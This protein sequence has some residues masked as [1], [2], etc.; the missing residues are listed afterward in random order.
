M[1]NKVSGGGVM[2]K[3]KRVFLLSGT[4]SEGYGVCYNFDT[5]DVTP[6][7]VTQTSPAISKA[8]WNDARRI[9]VEYPSVG[10]N[11]HFAGVISHKSDGVVGP[12]WIEIHEPGSI[13][14]VYAK[15]DCDHGSSGI[16]TNS[17]QIVTFEVSETSA[18]C[19]KFRDRGLPGAG[20]AIILQD[21]D[22]SS[23]NGLVMA[24][25]MTGQPS[26]GVQTLNLVSGAV[27]TSLMIGG[28]SVI[29]TAALVTTDHAAYSMS[30]GTY[31]GQTKMWDATIASGD[32]AGL[33]ISCAGCIPAL[34]L[35][36]VTAA[37]YISVETV[38]VHTAVNY[39]LMRWN[40]IAWCIESNEQV[41]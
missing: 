31:I 24:E 22:R 27:T 21:V 35:E 20:S 14:D 33:Q 23:T 12:N 25:L 18:D 39:A 34:S 15:V 32:A 26:G 7:N 9:M 29:S 2:T 8:D 19:G 4:A 36:Y 11:L 40:G 17:G 37:P 6:E 16:T 5:F 3:T 30:A 41:S 38:I 28:V 1:S 13:C 10:N